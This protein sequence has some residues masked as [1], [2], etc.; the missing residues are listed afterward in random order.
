MSLDGGSAMAITTAKY[1]TPS[2]RDVNKTKIRP[3]I[4]IEPSDQDLKNENDVQLKKAIEV[5]KAK[6]GTN[7]AQARIKS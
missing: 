1:L 5:L 6:I 3:D 4:V 7:Q 2:G